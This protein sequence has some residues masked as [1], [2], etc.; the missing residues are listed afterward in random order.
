VELNEYE[1][2]PRPNDYDAVSIVLIVIGIVIACIGIC[3]CCGAIKKHVFLLKMVRRFFFCQMWFWGR[4][5]A[6]VGCCP[7]KLLYGPAHKDRPISCV[8][9]NSF[10]K[11]HCCEGGKELIA[12]LTA[13]LH[14]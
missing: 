4:G 9:L 2:L 10:S 5:S 12:L 7:R 11:L 3:G 1:E 6:P 8:F 13:F 14:Y